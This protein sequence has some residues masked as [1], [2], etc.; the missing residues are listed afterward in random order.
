MSDEGRCLS[1]LSTTEHE[2]WSLA[3]SADQK[4]LVFRKLETSLDFYLRE[5]STRM[6]R[7]RKRF[8]S[9]IHLSIWNQFDQSLSQQLFLVQRLSL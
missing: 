2:S 5:F 9:M 1:L 7:L 3:T 6:S 8:V 4:Y